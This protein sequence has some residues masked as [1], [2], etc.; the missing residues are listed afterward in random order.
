[1]GGE[2]WGGGVAGVGNVKMKHKVREQAL[3]DM[4]LGCQQNWVE[5][6]LNP[7]KIPAPSE[8]GGSAPALH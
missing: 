6:I 2:A 7:N 1:M 8:E 3:M 5:R 4:K